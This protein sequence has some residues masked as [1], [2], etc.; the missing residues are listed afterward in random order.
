MNSRPGL[1]DDEI[2]YQPPFRGNRLGPDTGATR[3]EVLG[4]DLG[5]E[6]PGR[7]CIQVPR[8]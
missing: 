4:S 7:A 5:H 8:S 1:L 3:E 2:I 6:P